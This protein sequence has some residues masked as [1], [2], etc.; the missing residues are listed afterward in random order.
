MT[1]YAQLIEK[2]PHFATDDAAEQTIITT[3]L[4]T[5]DLE[6]GDAAFDSAAKV[7]RA[8]LL[9][10]AHYVTLDSRNRGHGGSGVGALTARTVQG[11]IVSF[12]VPE[13][14]RSEGLLKST[15]FG[16]AYLQLKR[17]SC[18]SLPFSL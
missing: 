8:R 7:A 1:T 4:E 12:A 11:A 6:V 16:L 17:T 5:A 2:Y 15:R 18:A 10:G 14:H 9:L 13:G 3:W